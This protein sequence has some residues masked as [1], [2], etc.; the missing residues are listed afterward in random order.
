MEKRD[1]I[2]RDASDDIA[3][4]IKEQGYSTSPPSDVETAPDPIANSAAEPAAETTKVADEKDPVIKEKEVEVIAPSEEPK[5]ETP[6]EVDYEKIL[7]EMSGGSIKSKDDLSKIIQEHQEAQELLQSDTY[8]YAAKL[9]AWEKEGHPTELFSPI[10]SLTAEEISAM[11]SSDVVAIKLKLENPD[12]TEE[13]ISLLIKEEYKQNKDIHSED[14][15]KAGSLRMQREAN[16]FRSK[17]NE[18]KNMTYV[19][20]SENKKAEAQAIESQRV[21]SW[22]KAV[23]S[24][25]SDLNKISVSLDEKG[26]TFEYTPTKEQKEEIAREMED[27]MSRAPVKFNE[28][29]IKAFKAIMQ[30]KFINRNINHISKA[31]AQKVSSKKEEEKILQIHNPTGAK[32]EHVPSATKTVR[33]EDDAVKAI[34]EA[35]GIRKR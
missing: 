10:Q 33:T 7:G 9:S 31:I 20:T 23:P 8:Q 2:T 25:V 11:E 18:L 12:W 32:A 5:Q 3:A 14:S 16:Q 22:K 13:D 15:V 27:I 30:E 19:P 1:D 26:T 4:L 35:E 28:D 21:E 29:G 34:M 24:F 17:L 6:V